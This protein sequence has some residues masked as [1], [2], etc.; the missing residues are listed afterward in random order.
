MYELYVLAE[1]ATTQLGDMF[2]QF[3]DRIDQPQAN[4]SDDRSS[5]RYQQHASVDGAFSRGVN[6]L[7]L[8]KTLFVR[9]VSQVLKLLGCVAIGSAVALF[10]VP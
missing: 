7:G 1:V 4:K 6:L 5:P 10:S 2:D 3:A 9:L 8:L